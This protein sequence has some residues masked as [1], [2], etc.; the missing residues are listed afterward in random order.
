MDTNNV[1][2]L[3]GSADLSGKEH[4]CVKMVAGP[5]SGVAIATSAD[6]AV[7]LGTLHRSAPHQEDGNYVGKAVAVFRRYA[8]VHFA[9]IGN[10]S[11]SVTPGT[12]L[13]L[14]PA[15]PGMLIPGGTAVAVA[16]DAFT[17]ATGNIV[18]VAFI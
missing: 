10:S 9:V 2:S 13:G 17:A 16:L 5:P 14:D 6:A 18:R 7:L 8:G 4:F 11:A 12:T 3:P 1:V 15:N